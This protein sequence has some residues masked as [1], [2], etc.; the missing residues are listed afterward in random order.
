MIMHG[1]NLPYLNK[2]LYKN[3][4]NLQRKNVELSASCPFSDTSL[5][6]LIIYTYNYIIYAHVTS[7]KSQRVKFSINV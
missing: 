3:S 5:V 4:I 6:I 7:Y 1:M 2:Q